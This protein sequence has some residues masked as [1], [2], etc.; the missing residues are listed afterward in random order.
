MRCGNRAS[1]DV[2]FYFQLQATHADR[3]GH[4]ALPVD[5]EFLTQDVQ[6]LLLGRN[7][8]GAGNFQHALHVLLR[9]FLVVLDGDDAVGIEALDVAARN[10]G[11]DIVNLARGHHFRFLH[12]AGDGFDGA[13]DI[14]HY[15]TF[16]PVHRRGSAANHAETPVRADF[17]HHANDLGGANVE[18]NNH[19]FVFFAHE[20]V[21]FTVLGDTG[22]T[23][24][25]SAKPPR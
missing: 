8:H 13:F 25:V 22:A 21:P 16:Q 17:S 18:T 9:D 5:D 3:L 4:A 7:M 10:A 19:I 14:H 2:H 20:D 15:A 24:G 11:V 12:G 1:G 6:D 23:C